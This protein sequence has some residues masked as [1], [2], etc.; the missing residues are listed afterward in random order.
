MNEKQDKKIQSSFTKKLRY[1]GYSI[2]ITALVIVLVVALNYAFGALEDRF[3]L[4]F[5]MS[6]NELTELSEE[7]EEILKSIDQPVH[8]YTVYSPDSANVSQRIQIETLL[9][10]YA[11]KNSE[12]TVSNIDPKTNPQKVRSYERDSLTISEGSVIVTNADE[13]RVKVISYMDFFTQQQNQY[14][15]NVSYSFTR[16]E[17]QIS[18]ALVYATSTETPRMYFLSNHGEVPKDYLS[19]FTQ[20]MS[21]E[22]MEA[23]EL[24]LGS[25]EA[26][27]LEAGDTVI[28]L[29]PTKDLL[30]EEYSKLSTWLEN[31]GRLLFAVDFQVDFEKLPNFNKLLGLYN[32]GFKDGMIVEDVD[33]ASAYNVYPDFIVPAMEESE[34]TDTL[35]EKAILLMPQNNRA[36]QY[37]E[38]PISGVQYQTLLKSSDKSVLKSEIRE[39]TTYT[40]QEG[41]EV[42]SQIL[43][44]TALRQNEDSD[45]DVRIAL[46]GNINMFADG[47]AN[48]T[49]NQDF[50]IST[51]KWLCNAQVDVRV[52]NKPAQNTSL[53]IPN[54]ESFWTLVVV[55]LIAIPVLVFA[56]GVFVWVRRRHL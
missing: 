50:L 34:I 42:D 8:I 55:T 16:A 52:P 13:S 7:T 51:L 25:A 2:V 49:S 48:A 53:A 39:E 47:L 20:N 11:A 46:I 31:G 44:L 12:I 37:P 22:N 10:R 29:K 40:A 27:E 4:S 35:P 15:G 3:A 23:L 26:P 6:G 21:F 30:D 9:G 36:I 43:A 14:S 17:S 56:G 19:M 38:M 33:N 28:I 5:D 54:S 41:D 32:L 24:N 1:G 18:S 45:K